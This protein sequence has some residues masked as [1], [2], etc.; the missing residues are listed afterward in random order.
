M[1]PVPVPAIQLKPHSK[2]FIGGYFSVL[3]QAL[4]A[5]GVACIQVITIPESRFEKCESDPAP[6]STLAIT[7]L[8]FLC[9]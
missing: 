5:N 1:F 3:D 4:N 6:Y 9:C 2:E 7:H 8:S